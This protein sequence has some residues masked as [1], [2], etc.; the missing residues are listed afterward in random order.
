MRR[1]SLLSLVATLG[2]AALA[3]S[4]AL[5]DGL[6]VI[7]PHPPERPQV[8]NVPLSV[9]Y[10]R[11]TVKVNERVAVTTVDQV[12]VNP[13]PRRVE[14]TY[15]FPLP[16][17]AAID[18]FSMWIDG[19]ETS[20]ELLDASRARGIYEN[21]VRQM[22]D[23]ALLEYADRGLFK[24]RIF[25]IE[26]N[27]EKRVKISYAE[28]LGSD[29]GT[30]AYRYPLNT[31][32]FSSTPLEHVSVDVTIESKNPITS[33]YS[34]SHSVD[35]P[36][37]LGTRVRLGWEARNVKPDR[38]FFLYWR[39]TQKDVG[40]SI[41]AHRELD[42]GTFLLV[43][44]P[45][46]QKEEAAIP[47]DVV[48]VMDTSGSMAG[49]KMDQARAALRYCLRSLRPEDR[50][51][52][53]PF[54]TE[55]RPFRDQLVTVSDESRKAAEKFV[56]GLEARGGTA[57]DDALK[58]SLGMLQRGKDDARPALVLF[59]TDGLPTIGET[60]ADRIVKHAQEAAPH[61]RLFVFGVG[62]DVNTRLL[63]RL[64]IENRGTRDYV[65]ESESIEEKVSNL[66]AKLSKPAMT[67]LELKIE[68]VETRA[69]HPR[70]LQDLFHGAEI[71]V[72]GRYDKP[73]NAVIRLKGKVRGE[74]REIVEEVRLPAAEEG[75]EFLPRLWGVRR[76]AF[77]LEEI[78]LRGESAELKDEVVRLARRY[79]IV[80]PYTS[81]LIL[82]DERRLPATAA[83]DE[84]EG[85]AS[86]PGLGGDWSASGPSTGGG[87][88]GPADAPAPTAEEEDAF[89]RLRRDADDAK[90]ATKKKSGADA[91]RLSREVK[92]LADARG[93]R[94]MD[95]GRQGAKDAGNVRH[96]AG[97]TFV[98]R[99][100]IWW[101]LDVDLRKKR[102]VIEAFGDEYF[103]LL[104]AHPTLGRYLT[105]G[106][107]VIN[108]GE[109]VI[110]VRAK[111]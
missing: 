20:A 68:G 48:F 1:S 99:G 80:T 11:V 6:I 16:T 28:V 67:D 49:D 54:A 15:L 100:G 35:V 87:G 29:N 82:E 71:L 70:R 62:N 10:H 36:R 40:V 93:D 8:R 72:V 37:E 22:K 106:S 101:D 94:D 23:P 24:A 76:V 88:A 33:V 108:V 78:R 51:A 75:N 57:I 5:A 12:F 4:P 110:E 97:R 21:I 50:F 43:L 60:D 19:K 81:Y 64:A 92:E 66:Y 3:A 109:R 30:V 90:A 2:L 73:G 96:V 79:G 18:R 86:R 107:V 27:S 53:V 65:A 59:V 32:K 103:A 58:Q 9:K 56:D 104:K 77:L 25:P 95:G 7:R 69:V 74:A 44:S 34:P 31:E 102:E 105:L 61:A 26:P 98:S 89:E 13:N 85:R 14:G 38:D 46:A 47:K 55:P 84:N 45:N 52:I 111:T 91:V 17:G 63:D 39:P 42:D 83:R 41:V